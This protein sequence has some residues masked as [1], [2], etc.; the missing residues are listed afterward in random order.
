MGAGRIRAL[1][2]GRRL[3]CGHG[4]PV[5]FLLGQRFEKNA[6]AFLTGGFRNGRPAAQQHQSSQQQGTPNAFLH[7]CNAPFEI[8]LT[9]KMPVE[10]SEQLILVL[11]QEPDQRNA[12]RKADHRFAGG[13][14]EHVH[15][16]GGDLIGIGQHQTYDNAVADHRGNGG[17]PELFLAYPPGDQSGQ[18]GRQRAED[19]VVDVRACQKIAQETAQRQADGGLRENGGQQG[20]GLGDPK[21]NGAEADGLEQ[22]RQR[23]IQRGDHGGQTE[24]TDGTVHFFHWNS[25]PKRKH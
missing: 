4:S 10:K 2:P 17:V 5:L 15:P 12:Q 11:V 1:A 7:G 18:Q 22:K 6:D 16:Q 20:H 24:G 19:Y 14:G 9:K 21:L 8:R 25:L 13:H 3:L 23:Q